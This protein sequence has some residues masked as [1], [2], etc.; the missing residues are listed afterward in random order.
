VEA[1]AQ[2]IEVQGKAQ[3]GLSDQTKREVQVEGLSA[4]MF[5]VRDSEDPIEI[6]G[7]TTY[8]IRIMNQGSKAA[9]NVQVAVS[10]PAGLQFVSA[11]GETHF[12]CDRGGIMF[13]PLKQLAPK[14]DTVYR[15]QVKG[16]QPGDQRVTVQVS[17]DDI[18]QP[19]RREES[20]RV[21]GDQ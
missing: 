16:V 21:F 8:E 13:Q 10:L 17:T 4:I 5:E 9:T 2:T 19:I 7:E 14:A 6:N 12:S 3:Q 15:V 1:G 11:S 20:T 18:N